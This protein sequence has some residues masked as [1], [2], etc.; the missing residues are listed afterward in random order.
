MEPEGK[1]QVG[2]RRSGGDLEVFNKAVAKAK[3]ADRQHLLNP[4]DSRPTFISVLY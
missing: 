2:I 1:I 3:G 4:V